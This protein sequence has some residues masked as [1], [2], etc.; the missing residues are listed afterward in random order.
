MQEYYIQR[1]GEGEETEGQGGIDSLRG[2]AHTEI[3]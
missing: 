3:K 2:R 1:E